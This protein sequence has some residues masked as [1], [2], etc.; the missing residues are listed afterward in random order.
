MRRAADATS[1]H[2]AES[3]AWHYAQLGHLYFERGDVDSAAR[4]YLRAAHAFPGHPYAETGL[5]RVATARGDYGEARRRYEALLDR[6]PTPEL[7]AA[8]GD[9]LAV[10]GDER[11][12]AAMYARA[13]SL[14]REGWENE[15]PQPAA[16]AR[17]LAERGLKTAEA[18]TLAERAA[19]GRSD[20]I[21]MDTLAWAYYRAGRLD[22]AARASEQA[23]RTG[24]KDRRILF[25]AAAIE[26]ARGNAAAARALL[27]DV[28]PHRQVIEPVVAR[29]VMELTDRL[30]D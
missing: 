30:T 27:G 22:E 3:L 7:A 20:I 15:E 4:E 19:A 8:V 17:L 14:E 29:G 1:A 28:V 23:R 21:T 6:S 24:T 12:A 11:G 25:H 10:T 9:L 18:V 13:E 2:D 5:A 16:L 26:Q